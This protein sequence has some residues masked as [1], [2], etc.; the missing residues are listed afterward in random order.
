MP[1]SFFFLCHLGERSGE[2][3]AVVKTL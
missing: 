1:S 3:S 2:Q